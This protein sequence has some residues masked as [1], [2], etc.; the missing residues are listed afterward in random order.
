M[1]YVGCRRHCLASDNA[2]AESLLGVSSF[3]VDKDWYR[4]LLD[5]FAR[6]VLEG[7]TV[8]VGDPGRID[9]REQFE[10]NFSAFVF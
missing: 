10:A 6:A 1:V 9:K 3:G 8:I 5:Y 4:L 7:D 2:F